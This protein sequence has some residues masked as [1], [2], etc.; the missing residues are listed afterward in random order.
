MLNSAKAFFGS[1]LFSIIF[2]PVPILSGHQRL[3]NLY[4]RPLL[5]LYSRFKLTVIKRTNPGSFYCSAFSFQEP[6]Y[7]TSS[8]SSSLTFPWPEIVKHVVVV[9]FCQTQLFQCRP[10]A[11]WFW[12]PVKWVQLFEFRFFWSNEDKID[13]TTWNHRANFGGS[14]HHGLLL[15]WSLS[16]LL[17]GETS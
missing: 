8:P 7:H 6:S 9:P 3:R 17:G 4:I 2:D 15:I 12:V 11:T 14:F 16:H 13:I 10:V 1:H 5:L